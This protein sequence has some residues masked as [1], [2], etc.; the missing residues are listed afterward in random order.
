[1]ENRTGLPGRFDFTLMFM[2]DPNIAAAPFG[3]GLPSDGVRPPT[4]PDALSI[5]TA[6][7]EQL[8]IK[9]ESARGLVEHLVIDSA[10]RPAAN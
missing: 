5:F 1:M 9:L 3:G 10:E 4:D 6:L 7:Q 8:G 2:R